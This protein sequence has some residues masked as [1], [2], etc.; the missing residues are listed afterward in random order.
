MARSGTMSVTTITLLGST[1]S[2]G[3]STLDVVRDDPRRFRVAALGAGGND[4][5]TLERQVREFSPRRVAVAGEAAAEELSR[6][7]GRR[8]PEV[9]AG[10]DAIA[11]LAADNSSDCLVNAIVGAAGLGSTLAAIGAVKRICL[12]NKESLVAAGTVVMDRIE[13]EGTELIPI[14]SEHSALHQCLDG[15][16]REGIARLVLTASGGPFRKLS[17]ASIASASVGDALAHPTWKM[18]RKIS[19]DSATLMNKGLEVI[20]AMHLFRFPADRIDV[21]IHPESVIHSMVEFNDGSILAQL[22]ETDMRHPVRYALSYPERMSARGSFDLTAM[23][24]LTFEAVDKKRFPCLAIALDAARKGGTAPAVMNA[25]NEVAVG[26][27]LEET[28]PFGAIPT[29]IRDTLGVVPFIESPTL[30]DLLGADLAARAEADRRVKN[31]VE[32]EA[33]RRRKG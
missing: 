8:R 4:L 32:E 2:I 11:A 24:P 25:A 33:V 3:R 26:A 19:I 5:D 14:D 6:R 29:I 9:A 30:D 20:E 31:G 12:A 16:K 22:G 10:P 1:G 15:R 27:F 13:R 17:A 21:V 28:I 7:L 23:G 18:G